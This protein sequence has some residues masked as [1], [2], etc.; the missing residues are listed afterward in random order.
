[1]NNASQPTV[2]LF[3]GQG[4]PVIGMGSDLWDLNASTKHIWDCASDISIPRSVETSRL[5]L[6]AVR[7]TFSSLALKDSEIRDE[8]GTMRGL[9]LR[10]CG[11]IGETIST[12]ESG[13]TIGPPTLREYAVEPELVATRR[14]SAQYVGRGLPSIDTSTPSMAGPAL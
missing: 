7:K 5:L 3:A 1:M 13:M 4:N 8:S 11:A 12:S 9:T 6:S 2:L 14:P 10:L